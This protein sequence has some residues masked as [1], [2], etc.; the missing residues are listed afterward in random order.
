MYKLAQVVLLVV[1]TLSMVGCKSC[2]SK[3]AGVKVPTG[4]T[5]ATLG[6]GVGAQDPEIGDPNP[7]STDRDPVPE[8]DVKTVYFAYDRFDVR[9]DQIPDLEKS[10]KFIKKQSRTIL[11]EGHCDERG[12]IEYNMSLGQKRA[13]AVKAFLVNRGVEEAKLSTIS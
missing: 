10:A 11:I 2:R 7:R 13:E 6:G 12:T 4:T 1:L 9:P 8:T 5:G 3:D